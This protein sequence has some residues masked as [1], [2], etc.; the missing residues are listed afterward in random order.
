M[1]VILVEFG[2]TPTEVYGP[3][4]T[5]TQAIVYAEEHELGGYTVA[6]LWSPEED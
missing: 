5:T 3:F 2:E 4:D 1:Y 6:E